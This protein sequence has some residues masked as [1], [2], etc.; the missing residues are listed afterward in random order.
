MEDQ[1]IR[2][3]VHTAWDLV[4]EIKRENCL[5][6]VSVHEKLAQLNQALAPHM[7]KPGKVG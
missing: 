5:L 1:N 2:T 7:D 6:P 3:L 4:A